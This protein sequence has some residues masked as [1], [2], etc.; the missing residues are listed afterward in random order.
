MSTHC[1]DSSES[2]IFITDFAELY[3]ISLVWNRST[4][5]SNGHVISTKQRDFLAIFRLFRKSY[6]TLND[7]AHCDYS[8]WKRINWNNSSANDWISLLLNCN[9]IMRF[10]W[11][12]FH[13][14]SFLHLKKKEEKNTRV[15]TI[16]KRELTSEC[17]T[18]SVLS[19]VY[20]KL[21]NGK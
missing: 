8:E 21:H 10:E 16:K 15:D 17:M 2:W 5:Y 3:I 13:F 18:Y 14:I 6:E 19:I 12:P 7:F 20:D 9:Q 11:I 4:E 1:N